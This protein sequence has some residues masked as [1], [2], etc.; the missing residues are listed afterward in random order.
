MDQ[1]GW[2]IE[3]N[4]LITLVVA[5]GEK[6]MYFVTRDASVTKYRWRAEIEGCVTVAGLSSGYVGRHIFVENH[7]IYMI[8]KYVFEGR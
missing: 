8:A 2:V 7:C 1:A 4:R 3:R 6:V 5:L